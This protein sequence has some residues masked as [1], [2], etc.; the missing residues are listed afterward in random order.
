[1]AELQLLKGFP[2]F[3]ALRMV[4]VVNCGPSHSHWGE[5]LRGRLTYARFRTTHRT[6]SKH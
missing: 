5:D 2:L 4:S 6:V 3:T 1:M